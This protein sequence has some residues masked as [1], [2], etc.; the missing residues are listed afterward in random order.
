MRSS[1]GDPCFIVSSVNFSISHVGG[2]GTANISESTKD[3]AWTALLWEREDL[4]NFWDG[5]GKPVF[6]TRTRR[7]SSSTTTD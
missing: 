4:I 3:D 2:T 1:D 7:P 5:L 6:G